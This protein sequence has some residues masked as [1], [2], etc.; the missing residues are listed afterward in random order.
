MQDKK[1]LGKNHSRLRQTPDILHSIISD[2][3]W[4]VFMR[5][6]STPHQRALWNPDVK[7][8]NVETFSFLHDALMA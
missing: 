8:E 6:P 2:F 7:I 3:F 5:I 4:R 1:I